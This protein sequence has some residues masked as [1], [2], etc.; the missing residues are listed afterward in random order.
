MLLLAMITF[1]KAEKRSQR[2]LFGFNPSVPD[3]LCHM[4]NTEEGVT[5][6]EKM[7]DWYHMTSSYNFNEIL[8]RTIQYLQM[9]FTLPQQFMLV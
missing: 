7:D 2:I 3:N 8:Y 6:S 9:Y 5:N 1:L 4:N